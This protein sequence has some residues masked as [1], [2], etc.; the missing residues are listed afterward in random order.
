ML[1][2]ILSWLRN[3]VRESFLLGIQDA[4]AELERSGT[5]G[6]ESPALE[7]LRARFAI[8]EERKGKKVSQ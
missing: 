4:V 8:S 1:Q 6:D 5:N 3:A 7:S 2:R